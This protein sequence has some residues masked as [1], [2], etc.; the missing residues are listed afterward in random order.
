MISSLRNNA[1]IVGG[2][3]AGSALSR[4]LAK[5]GRETVLIEWAKDPEHK[6]CGDF[7]GV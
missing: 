2:G 5:A 3:P 4:A 7:H 1:L 6:V